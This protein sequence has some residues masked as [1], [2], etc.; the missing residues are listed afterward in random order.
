M[1]GSHDSIPNIKKKRKI[2]ATITVV[3]K[4]KSTATPQIQKGDSRVV[5]GKKFI[6]RMSHDI[7]AKSNKEKG[8]NRIRM[9]RDKH[10]KK[11]SA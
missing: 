8:Q 3:K 5:F 7:K 1:H 6:A 2:I 9:E 10:K 11:R 4:M